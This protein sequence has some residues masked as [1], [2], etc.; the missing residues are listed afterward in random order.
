M[1]TPS[2]T[3]ASVYIYFLIKKNKLTIIY[4]GVRIFKVNESWIFEN[5]IIAFAI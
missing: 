1:S 2:Y 4:K 3:H 5:Y